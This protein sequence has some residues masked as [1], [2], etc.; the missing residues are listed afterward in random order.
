MGEERDDLL[1]V[2]LPL[3]LGVDQQKVLLHDPSEH[4]REVFQ[5]LHLHPFKSK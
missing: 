3:A 1:E 4:K 2:D 5:R